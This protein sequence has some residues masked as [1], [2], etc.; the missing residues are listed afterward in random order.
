MDVLIDTFLGPVFFT[1]AKENTS[2]PN[3]Y[4]NNYIKISRPTQGDEPLSGPFSCSDG[5]NNVG[6]RFI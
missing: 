3:Y 5:G 4:M 6:G 1:E 2:V